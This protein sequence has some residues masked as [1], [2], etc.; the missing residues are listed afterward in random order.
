MNGCDEIRIQDYVLGSV[1]AGE[2]ARLEEHLRDCASCRR[3]VEEYEL[4]FRELGEL[5]T[6][7]TPAGIPEAVLARLDVRSWHARLRRSLG[8]YAERPV[9]AACAG[10]V[11]GLLI[12]VFR[13]PILLGLGQLAGMLATDGSAGLIGGIQNA[14]TAF[15]KSTVVLEVLISAI[16]HL[17]PLAR[18]LGEVLLRSLRQPSG[19]TMVLVLFTLLVM[20]RLVGRVRREEFSHAKR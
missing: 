16:A 14:L 15:T 18:A 7:P 9:A 8:I 5:P 17:E 20:G 13:D 2:T 19:L 1:T 11:A 12:A 3:E 10:I 4:L 6:P